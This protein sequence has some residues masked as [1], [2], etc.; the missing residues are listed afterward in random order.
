MKNESKRLLL[1]TSTTR[2]TDDIGSATA[3]AVG[4]ARQHLNGFTIT[5]VYLW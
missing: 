5:R 3:T 1:V 4:G 2:D